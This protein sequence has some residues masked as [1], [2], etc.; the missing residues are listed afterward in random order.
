MGSD[1][2]GTL[3]I[4]ST[5]FSF[6]DGQKLPN[7]SLTL[8]SKKFERGLAIA[9]GLNEVQIG[10]PPPGIDALLGVT[11]I[12]MENPGRMSF[13]I[14]TD[15]YPIPVNRIYSCLYKRMGFPD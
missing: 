1:R 10:L 8:G 7:T 15:K 14:I 12:K 11:R 4:M 13:N 5:D 6:R 2:L 9:A 3:T